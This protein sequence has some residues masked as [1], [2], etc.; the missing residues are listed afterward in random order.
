MLG[1]TAAALVI[2]IVMFAGFGRSFLPP[3]N[4]GSLTVN[5]ST[6]PGISLE[7][8]D[9]IGRRAERALL[10]IPEIKVVGR[11]T[12]RAELDEHALGINTSEIEAPFELSNRTKDE[13]LDD[14]RH[15]LSE[16]PGINVEVGSP[17][18]HRI[19]AMLSGTRAGIAIKLFGSDLNRMYA[20][21][22]QIRDAIKDIEGIA[23]LNVEQQV[24]WATKPRARVCRAITASRLSCSLSPSNPTSAP[25]T[26]Q[27]ISTVRLPT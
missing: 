20:I 8:S 5:V 26:L 25:S 13:L 1:T 14:V 4:E 21:G 24:E 11:K 23:D 27:P 16:I 19:D 10:S 3:F 17:I 22:N 9:S 15:R 12:G 18:S 2:A 7:E 6:L